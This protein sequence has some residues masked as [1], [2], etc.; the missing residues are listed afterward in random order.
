MEAIGFLTS[1]RFI[2]NIDAHNIVSWI[3]LGTPT[4]AGFDAQLIEIEDMYHY[5]CKNIGYMNFN[6][7]PR[8]VAL[9]VSIKNC[10]ESLHL[11]KPFVNYDVHYIITQMV[12]DL[13][14]AFSCC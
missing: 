14:W 13:D 2:E 7:E 10:E 3:L 1:T 12:C 6:K 5:Y 9:F 8:L 4:V 11:I